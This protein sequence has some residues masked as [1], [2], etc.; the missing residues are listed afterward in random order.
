MLSYAV[1]EAL[2]QKPA[3]IHNKIFVIY[4][5]ATVHNEIFVIHTTFYIILYF[6]LL[7][8]SEHPFKQEKKSMLGNK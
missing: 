1:I 8:F 7:S 6:S 5:A 4:I 3:T 2:H